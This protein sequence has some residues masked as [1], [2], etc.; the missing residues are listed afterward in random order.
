MAMMSKP[1]RFPVDIT[2]KAGRYLRWTTDHGDQYTKLPPNHAPFAA[3]AS[4]LAGAIGPIPLCATLNGGPCEEI[5]GSLVEG[6]HRR[7]G[8]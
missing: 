4:R 3:N 8:R 5:W 1:T 7:H 6:Q 2:R